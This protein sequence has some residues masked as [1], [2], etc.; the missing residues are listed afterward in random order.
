MHVIS[1][2]SHDRYLTSTH[3]TNWKSRGLP[4]DRYADVAALFGKT[5]DELLGIQEPSNVLPGPNVTGSVPLLSTVQAG[6]YKEIIDQGV[7]VEHIATVAPTKR[8]TYALRI[9]GDS[10]EPTFTQGMIVIIEPDADPMPNDYVVAINGNNEA[11][12]KQLIKDGS[13]WFLKPLNPRYPIRPL[14][15]AKVTGVCIGAQIMFKRG[16]L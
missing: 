15:N 12:F 1:F 3:I 7:D 4:A 11:T 14:G 2:P 9:E 13:E 8:Y 10:M 16:V 5:I 6:M